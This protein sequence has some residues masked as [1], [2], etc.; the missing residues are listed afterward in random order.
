MVLGWVALQ[1]FAGDPWVGL[2]R[3]SLL[4]FKPSSGRRFFPSLICH[5]LAVFGTY[6]KF[7]TVHNLSCRRIRMYQTGLTTGW[8]VW[9]TQHFCMN[10][11]SLFVTKSQPDQNEVRHRFVACS[12]SGIERGR[13]G[14]KGRKQMQSRHMFLANVGYVFNLSG[15]RTRMDTYFQPS[16]WW[17]W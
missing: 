15:H 1:C 4:M 5:T 16:C 12:L 8:H 13:K 14:W 7:Q 9:D 17:I 11:L 2:W 10:F 3:N 6:T